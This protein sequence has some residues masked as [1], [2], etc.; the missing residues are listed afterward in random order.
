[1]WFWIKQGLRGIKAARVTVFLNILMLFIVL[2]MSGISV[3]VGYNLLHGI[4]NLQDRFIIK[5][6][7][8]PA[9]SEQEAEKLMAEIRQQGVMGKVHL[10]SPEE[11]L[12]ILNEYL[13]ANLSDILDENPLPYVIEGTISQFY[14]NESN[15]V[16][17]IQKWEKDERILHI[18]VPY[19][20]LRLLETYGYPLF[21]GILVFLIFVL[22]VSVKLVRYTIFISVKDREKE[23]MLTRLLGGTAFHVRM[24]ILIEGLLIGMISGLMVV[25]ALSFTHSFL[26]YFQL[27][28]LP[29]WKELYLIIF[30]IALFT[31]IFGSQ[32]A[33]RKFVYGDEEML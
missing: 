11:G 30:L 10:I 15:L 24:P 13:G 4:K 5:I 9:L 23:I 26:Q 29:F 25:F 8:N 33:V 19:T 14:L 12:K 32:V 28:I 17:M 6:Y 22:A 18:D 21:L 1:M 3:I 2:Y 20:L 16:P 31:G 27:A 7:L